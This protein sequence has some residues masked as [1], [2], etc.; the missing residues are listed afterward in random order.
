M[1]AKVNNGKSKYNSYE[2]DVAI[3]NFFFKS[4]KCFEFVRQ[5]RLTIID[6]I[7][8]VGGLIGLCMG[9]SFVSAMELLYWLTIKMAKNISK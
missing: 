9:I 3:A 2:K 1:F 6:F 4:S 8:N 7:S 5:P